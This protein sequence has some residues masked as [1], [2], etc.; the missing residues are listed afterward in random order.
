MDGRNGPDRSDRSSLRHVS[1]L[2]RPDGRAQPRFVP[3]EK[4]KEP[5]FQSSPALMDGRNTAAFLRRCA[6]HVRVSILA[7]PD[8]RA[9]LG[10]RCR[11]RFR[12]YSFNPRPP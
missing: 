9:Q 2:A 10:M 8:G 11:N 3:S 7:R 12:V 4:T 1:I 5:K 6:L